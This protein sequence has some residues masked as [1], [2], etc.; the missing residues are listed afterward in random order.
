M[1]ETLGIAKSH[2]NRRSTCKGHRYK[3]IELFCF[4]IQKTTTKFVTTFALTSGK[5]H[6]V[7]IQMIETDIGAH[8]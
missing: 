7:R 6:M 8:L 3:Q 5:M 1:R 4:R 2:Y